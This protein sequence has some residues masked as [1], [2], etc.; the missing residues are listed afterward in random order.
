[1]T[2]VRPRWSGTLAA[3]QRCTVR[4]GRK[5]AVLEAAEAQNQ[6]ALVVRGETADR[7]GFTAISDL[8][9]DA[10]DGARRAPECPSGHCGS[11]RHRPQSPGIPSHTRVGP[12]CMWM[13][14]WCALRRLTSPP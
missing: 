12:I 14:S 11:H 9:P 8:S 13:W 5:V 10:G 7:Q 6:N 4:A 2:A 3:V 1:M